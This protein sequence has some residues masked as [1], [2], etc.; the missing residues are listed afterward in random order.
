MPRHSAALAQRKVFLLGDQVEIARAVLAD[1]GD[2][3]VYDEGGVY[4]HDGARWDAVTPGECARAVYKYSGASDSHRERNSPL[5]VWAG[6]ASGIVEVLRNLAERKFFADAPAG[7]TFSGTF[8]R[9]HDRHLVPE[10]PSPE[11]RA[12]HAYPF[13]FDNVVRAPRF[14]AMLRDVWDGDADADSKVALLQEYVGACLVGLG[15]RTKKV[16]IF[17]GDTDSGKSTVLSV[18]RSIFPQGSVAAVRP[19]EF[20]GEY[21]RA[22]LVGILANFVSELPESDWLDPSAFKALTG[23][24]LVNARHPYGKPFSFVAK[25]GHI[26]AANSLPRINDRSEA[27]WNRLT[28]VT[29]NNRFHVDPKNGER[30]AVRGLAQE[31]VETEREGVVAWAV[32]GLKR[33]LGNKMALTAVA[34]SEEGVAALRN[35]SDQLRVFLD[36]RL[37]VDPRG[38]PEAA[39]V[40]Q[41]YVDWT[42][43]THHPTLSRSRFG[44]EFTALLRR[45]TGLREP[46]SKNSKGSRTY[47]GVRFAKPELHYPFNTLELVGES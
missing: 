33:L 41:Q 8:L 36:D 32:E 34:T 37:V 25:A 12:R 2:E 9:V 45:M 29:F 16:L 42:H 31:I 23:D 38:N 1:L 43:E 15:A 6:M 18:L 44:R 30:T 28:I 17:S 46:H 14:L 22:Q 26:Y 4:R 19:S 20:S 39:S 24:D 3:I 21:Q 35:D 27:S 5:R 47:S 13:R 40:Y 11:H 10:R 7:M